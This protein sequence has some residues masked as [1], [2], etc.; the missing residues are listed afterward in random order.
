MMKTLLLSAAILLGSLFTDVEN[1]GEDTSQ[2]VILSEVEEV[3]EAV[4]TPSFDDTMKEEY[5][6]HLNKGFHEQLVLGDAT[7]ELESL[8]E[9]LDSHLYS[10]SNLDVKHRFFY[11]GAEHIKYEEVR[12]KDISK[13][14]E[15]S[16]LAKLGADA[17]L[18]IGVTVYIQNYDEGSDQRFKFLFDEINNTYYVASLIDPNVIFEINK[19]DNFAIEDFFNDGWIFIEGQ[20]NSNFQYENRYI[21]RP[22][23]G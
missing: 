7:F 11:E 1:L 12:E 23:V 16:T 8:A 13:A 5:G 10:D 20:H 9:Q 15:N 4:D 18:L 19:E 22:S 2:E 14:L 21:K 3:T 6:I 17:D